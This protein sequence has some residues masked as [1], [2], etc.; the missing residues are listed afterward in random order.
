LINSCNLVGVP[1]YIMFFFPQRLFIPV[2]LAL[3]GLKLIVG[4]QI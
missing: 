3:A 1:F 2:S 4:M